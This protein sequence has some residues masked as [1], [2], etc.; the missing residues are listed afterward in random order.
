MVTFGP[1]WL[2]RISDHSPPSNAHRQSRFKRFLDLILASLAFVF[3]L[4][5]AL[6]VAVAISLD[7]R[8]PVLYS[9]ERVGIDRRRRRGSAGQRDE[10]RKR[11]GYGRPFTIYKFRSMVSDAEKKTGPVWAADHDPRATRVGAFLRRSHLD[12]IPQL[13]NVLRGDMSMVGPRP[14]RP[15]LFGNLVAQIPQYALRCRVLPGITGIAQIKNGYDD[16]LQSAARKV[17]YDLYYIHNGSTLMDLQIM[18]ATALVLARGK[19]HD[20]AA[21]AGQVRRIPT[22]NGVAGLG[23]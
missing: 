20:P 16:S 12:E 10:R 23:A 18:A 6:M 14:E 5:V 8:G 11:Q 9:Q 2:P 19:Q 3:A 1:R 17:E 13:L 7:S 21:L 15:Q 4:P 22:R